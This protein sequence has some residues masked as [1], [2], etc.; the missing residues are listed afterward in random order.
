MKKCGLEKSVVLKKVRFE[1]SAVWKK[2]GS[3]KVRFWKKC[4]SKKVRFWKKCGLKKCGLEKMYGSVLCC[5]CSSCGLCSSIFKSMCCFMRLNFESYA[6]LIAVQ[7]G[8]QTA[9]NQS[10]ISFCFM[11]SMQV[12]SKPHMLNRYHSA[13]IHLSLPSTIKT[14]Q[15]RK[16]FFL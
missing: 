16:I 13:R 7:F 3:K 8:G 2:C 11:W 10:A 6:V 4:G 9:Q 1:K 12:F 14:F 15:S 5:P